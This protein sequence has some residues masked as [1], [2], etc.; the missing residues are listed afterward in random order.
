MKKINTLALMTCAAMTF[1]VLTSAPGF[2]ADDKMMMKNDG[3]AMEKSGSMEKM[4][5]ME[6]MDMSQEATFTSEAFT[7]AQ[8]SGKPFFVAFHKKG[9]PMCAEQKQA[10]NAIYADPAYKDL[11]VLVVDYLND[12]ESL[13]KFNVGMQG[14]LILYK[15]ENE[16][17]RSAGLVKSADIV[18]QIKG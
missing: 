12:T 10:L 4:D 17:S 18:K 7:E 13:K 14:A 16:V 8:A 9:C 11:K 2:A 3:M 15:G 6:K 5:K 1:G